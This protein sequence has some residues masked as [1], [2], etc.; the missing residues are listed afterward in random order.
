MRG[1][2]KA[3]LS[4]K[5]Y[6]PVKWLDRYGSQSVNIGKSPGQKELNEAL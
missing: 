5:N 3:I 4:I 6:F 1:V 2:L